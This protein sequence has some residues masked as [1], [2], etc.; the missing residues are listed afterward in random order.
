M[1]DACISPDEDFDGQSYQLDWPGTF[2]NP[3]LDRL[4]HPTPVLF[5]SPVTGLGR[6]YSTIAFET[7]LPDIENKSPGQCAVL[8][9]DT[10]AG[11]VVPPDGAAFYPF[12]TT[13]IRDGTCTWQEGGNFIPGTINHFGG[14][15][16]AE[17]GQ[18]L[19]VDYPAPG[20]TTSSAFETTT[21][22]ISAMPVPSG[23]PS[24]RRRWSQA[25]GG[26]WDGR[27]GTL[28]LC[29]QR[30]CRPNPLDPEL[31]YAVV[32]AAEARSPVLREQLLEMWVDVTNAG[33]AVGFTAPADVGAV[34]STLDAALERVAAGTDL[35][36][37]LRQDG[38]AV[39]M[40]FL[41]DGNRRCGGTGARS[42]A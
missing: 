29:P 7:D 13:T 34:A 25:Q 32:E 9:P 40:A 11:C 17:Y 14:S 15:A 2:K 30:Q 5:T 8:R 22:E 6:N 18:L 4:L 37:I 23:S 27:L 16:K 28:A 42:C 19:R 10:G 39:G 31:V 38:T 12:F 26:A 41:V 20:A 21:A 35:L 24:G 1:I 36:G 3:F 33:G